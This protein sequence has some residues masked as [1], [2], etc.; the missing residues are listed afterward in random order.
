VAALVLRGRIALGEG[1]RLALAYGLF[2]TL[3]PLATFHTHPHTFIFMLPA[4]TAIIATLG[5]DGD[6]RRAMLFGC[7]FAVLFVFGGMPSVATPI[8]RLLHTSL[9]PSLLFADPIWANVATVLT[10]SGYALL[11]TRMARESV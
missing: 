11:R 2:F 5:E 3:M 10:L 9:A 1:T 7:G 4:W 6:R 8:D